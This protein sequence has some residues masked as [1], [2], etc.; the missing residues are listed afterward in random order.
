MSQLPPAAHVW[1]PSG[2]SLCDRRDNAHAVPADE[3]TK[4]CAAC[5]LA[6]YGAYTVAWNSAAEYTVDAVDAR[7]ALDRLRATRW[8]QIESVE[9]RFLEEDIT[10]REYPWPIRREDP[11]Q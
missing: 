2:R 3:D 10:E 4:F 8:A 11:N 6:A 9:L 1:L 5:L 7:E